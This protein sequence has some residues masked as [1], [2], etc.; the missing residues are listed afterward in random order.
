[1]NGSTLSLNYISTKKELFKR[2]WQISD[3]IKRSSINKII[4]E[5]RSIDINQ[6]KVKKIITPK[7]Y[8]LFVE[9]FGEIA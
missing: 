8:Y 7:E 4:S 1:M 2:Y 5:T 9:E 3:R 6:A